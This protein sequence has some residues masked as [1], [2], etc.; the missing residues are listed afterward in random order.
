MLRGQ[1]QESCCVFAKRRDVGR[2]KRD[3][4]ISDSSYLNRIF[5]SS[6]AIRATTELTDIAE[7]KKFF[8]IIIDD[9]FETS[10]WP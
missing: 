7:K 9:G 2:G 10:H 1:M 6:I 3:S 8:S 4:R 5:S